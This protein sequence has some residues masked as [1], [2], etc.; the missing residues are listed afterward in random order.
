MVSEA[1]GRE[2]TVC[3]LTVYGDLRLLRIA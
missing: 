3:A 1:V 2:Y